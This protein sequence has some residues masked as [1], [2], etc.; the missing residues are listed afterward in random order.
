MGRPRAPN[1]RIRSRYWRADPATDVYKIGKGPGLSAGAQRQSH[2]EIRG[3][4]GVA[5]ALSPVL[6]AFSVLPTTLSALLTAAIGLLLA[7]LLAALLRVTL[8]LLLVPLTVLLVL[9]VLVAGHSALL[10]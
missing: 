1:A 7:M 8:L 9:L 3:S 5:V 4:V 6:T 10:S 2:A